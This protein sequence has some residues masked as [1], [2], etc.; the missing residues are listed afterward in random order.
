MKI[1]ILLSK[2]I[3]AIRYLTTGNCSRLCP[4][5]TCS[6][7]QASH[8]VYCSGY[9]GV[10]PEAILKSTEWRDNVYQVDVDKNEKDY[11]ISQEMIIKGVYVPTRCQRPTSGQEGDLGLPYESTGTRSLIYFTTFFSS[12][13]VT[14]RNSK[15]SFALSTIRLRSG[16]IRVACSYRVWLC[17]GGNTRGVCC[18]YKGDQRGVK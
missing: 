2:A 16:I 15:S 8:Y 1:Y 18:F 12:S 17:C 13:S 14:L 3:T 11:K 9:S 6:N 4:E 5:I 10:N 7:A